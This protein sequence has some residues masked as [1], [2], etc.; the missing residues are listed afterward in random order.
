M[1]N[2]SEVTGMED[3]QES[4][5]VDGQDQ[6]MGD[7]VPEGWVDEDNRVFVHNLQDWESR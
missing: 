7:G 3:V 5:S 2:A 1:T 4:Q 6:D